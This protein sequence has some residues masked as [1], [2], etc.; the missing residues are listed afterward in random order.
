MQPAP[1]VSVEW[2]TGSAWI[3]AALLLSAAALVSSLL[4]AAGVGGLG[5][6]LPAAS[7]LLVGAGLW[8]LRPQPAQRLRWDGLAWWLMPTPAGPE[9]IGEVRLMLDLGAHLLLQFAAAEP[10]HGPRRH[11]LALSRFATLGDWHGLRCAL[12]CSGVVAAMPAATDPPL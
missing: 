6:L 9:R 3:V 5:W 10:G 8:S 7:V 12:Y 1:A 11:W 2:R 4:W